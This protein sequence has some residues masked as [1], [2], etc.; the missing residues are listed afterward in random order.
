MNLQNIIAN[1]LETLVNQDD[2]AAA[3]TYGGTTISVL[4][5][6]AGTI[7]N[8]NGVLVETSAPQATCLSS[9]VASA[10]HNDTIT[11]NGITY[12]IMQ[13][14]PDGVGMSKLILS[15]DQQ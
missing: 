4:F 13:I 14:L 10:T 12:Y 1:D 15:E 8:I 7:Q 9:D 11:I 2:F 3:A 5:D 6:A